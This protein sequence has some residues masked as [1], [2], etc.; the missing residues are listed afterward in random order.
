MEGQLKLKMS[1]IWLYSG[2]DGRCIWGPKSM[3]NGDTEIINAEYDFD[4]FVNIDLVNYDPYALLLNPDDPIGGYTIYA[5]NYGE[6]QAFFGPE[7]GG[8]RAPFYTLSYE[9]V[10]S[11]TRN[12]HRQRYRLDLLSLT[13]NDAQQIIDSVYITVNDQRIWHRNMKTGETRDINQNI[14]FHELISVAL[15]EEDNRNSDPFGSF[16]I[17]SDAL[18]INTGTSG[19]LPI[20]RRLNQTFRADEGI[21]GDARYTLTYIIR[22]LPREPSPRRQRYRLDLQSLTCNDAQQTTDH[23][24]IKANGE[25]IWESDIKTGQ[26]RDINQNIIFHELIS[27]DLWEEDRHFNPNDLFGSF[28]IR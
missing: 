16:Q 26:T 28:Q 1:Y 7:L 3:N 18:A 14:I 21:V 19:D 17:R 23:V 24:F 20:N 13:C 8:A 6:H 12:S 27:V 25:R 5:D 2:S 10:D 22:Q 11:E 15:W 4:R 9:V